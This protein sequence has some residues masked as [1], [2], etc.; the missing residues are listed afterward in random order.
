MRSYIDAASIV[1]D[2]DEIPSPIPRAIPTLSSNIG[3]AREYGTRSKAQ[4]LEG[5]NDA[6]VKDDDT[7]MTMED[8]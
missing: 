2:N 3:M 8:E 1:S 4:S 7:M 6:L 5:G